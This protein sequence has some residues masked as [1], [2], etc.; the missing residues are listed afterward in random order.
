M[1]VDVE[2]SEFLE[3]ILR[4]LLFSAL[5]IASRWLH[6]RNRKLFMPPC[7]SFGLL[8]FSAV[9]NASLK[10]WRDTSLAAFVQLR[11]SHASSQV[12]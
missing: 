12:L 11:A 9:E 7:R 3:K 1:F 8:L 4:L 2:T 10:P 6:T 5:E